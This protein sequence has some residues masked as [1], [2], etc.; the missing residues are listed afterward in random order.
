M[1]FLESCT[2]HLFTD[3]TLDVAQCDVTKW[4]PRIDAG[5]DTT[6]IASADQQFVARYLGIARIIAKG[7]KEEGRHP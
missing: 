4:K 6:D 1:D 7:S 3:D 5:C 2:V